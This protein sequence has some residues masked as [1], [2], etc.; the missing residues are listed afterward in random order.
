MA[1]DDDA[2][3]LHAAA[4]DG[5]LDVMGRTPLHH[6]ACSGKARAGAVLV[7]NDANVNASDTDGNTPLHLSA[8]N[9]HRLVTSMLLWGGAERGARNAKGNT[10]LH[11]AAISNAKDVAL[12]ILQNDDE[13]WKSERNHEGKL[14]LDLAREVGSK[15]VLDV[16][17]GKAKL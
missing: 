7:E 17:E 8:I 9:R 16:L 11:E 14:P 13:D 10:A 6:A 3:P 12:L 15:D 2:L 5:R 1:G 4:R